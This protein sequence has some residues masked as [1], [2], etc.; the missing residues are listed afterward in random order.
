MKKVF[1]PF[2]LSVMM[3]GALFAQQLSTTPSS[4]MSEKWWSSRFEANKERAQKGGVDV[5]FLGDSITDFWRN[6]GWAQYNK[7]FGEFKTI[8]MGYSADRTEH[9][10][11][12]LDNGEMNGANPK[13]IVL[14]IGTNNTGH[15]FNKEKRQDT[16]DGI[17][18]ILDRLAKITPQSKVLLLPIFPRGEKKDNPMR[19]RND[20]VNA[21]IKKFADNKRVFWLDFNQKFLTPDGTLPTD[22]MPDLLHPNAKGYTIW[23]ESIMP[24]VRKTVCASVTPVPREWDWW[25]Q[26][27]EQKCKLAKSK[28]WDFVFLGDS[29]THGWEGRGKKEWDTLV[30]P[31]NALNLGYGADRTE[32]VLWRLD[33]GEL[34]GVN[35]KVIFV[36]IG[37]N[38]TGH[39]SPVQE[40]PEDTAKGIRAILDRLAKIA[41]NAKIVLHP[42]FPRGALHTDPL[43][44]RNE[45]VNQQIQSFADGRRVFWLDFNQKFLQAD[46]TLS[47]EIMGDL[48]H[49][50]PK[51]Y[52]IWFEA[53]KPTMDRYRY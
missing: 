28:K 45:D 40:R 11:W 19:A 41:P 8:N 44:L 10:L 23:A 1:M 9:V 32:H 43:R 31:Y 6:R 47:K 51:G 38:N 35:P 42:I 46:G 13:V 29:I 26:R 50:T 18:A 33:H 16:V 17:R 4:R 53:I 52:Q 25:K 48:L 15:R 30:A 3:A 49:P 21:E 39:N 14:M 27:F 5:V 36:M 34:D 24:F 2:L 20:A 12:R 37:T 7:Y 22:I